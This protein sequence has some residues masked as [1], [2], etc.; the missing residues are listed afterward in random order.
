MLKAWR[1][2]PIDTLISNELTLVVARSKNLGGV[3]G[4]IA[5]FLIKRFNSGCSSVNGSGRILE[6]RASLPY[7]FE[8]G[9]PDHNILVQISFIRL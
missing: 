6:I 2:N 8:S 5:H 1:R 4:V 9:Y 3:F 7:Q